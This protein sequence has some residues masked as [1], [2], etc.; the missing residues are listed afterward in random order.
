MNDTSTTPAF[1][2]RLR[3]ADAHGYC[4]VSADTF[5]EAAIG[6]AELNACDGEAVSVEVVDCATGRTRCFRIDLDTG[7]VS[8]C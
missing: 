3:E 1:L 5:I 2:A 6:F 8:A 7:A 4:P